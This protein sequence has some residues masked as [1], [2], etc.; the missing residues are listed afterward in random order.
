MG[1]RGEGRVTEP[2]YRT[3][4]KGRRDNF[5]PPPPPPIF[6]TL[7]TPQPCLEIQ[8]QGDEGLDRLGTSEGKKSGGSDPRETVTWGEARK[9]VVQPSQRKG[10]KPNRKTTPPH[11]PVADRRAR[12]KGSP[13]PTYLLVVEEGGVGDQLKVARCLGSNLG[14]SVNPRN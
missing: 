11:L 10:G 6:K 9:Q 14:P 13:H 8:D 12:E 7:K 5:F 3:T 1:G 2:F 4:S